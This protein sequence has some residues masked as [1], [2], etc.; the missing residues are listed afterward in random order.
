M[1]RKTIQC[2]HCS[3]ENIWADANAHF[4]YHTQEWQLGEIMPNYF[5]EQ[6]DGDCAVKDIDDKEQTADIPPYNPKVLRVEDYQLGY[7]TGF[8]KAQEMHEEEE[9]YESDKF[10]GEEMEV[11]TEGDKMLK[12]M[13]EAPKTDY[14]SECKQDSVFEVNTDQDPVFVDGL[15]LRECIKCGRYEEGKGE[16]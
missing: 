8:K 12:D 16:E 9:K 11:I 7:E 4:N 14:C 6:C 15:R 10:W 1:I 2:T 5:C 3:S 13:M